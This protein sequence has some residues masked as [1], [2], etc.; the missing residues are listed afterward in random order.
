MNASNSLN[1]SLHFKA[2]KG[3]FTLPLCCAALLATPNFADDLESEE[4]YRLEPTIIITAIVM[5]SKLDELNRN[6][7]QINGEMI[8]QKGFIN[9][10]SVFRY[11]SFVS[12]S[13][14]GLGGNLDIRGQ[15]NKANTSVQTLINGV[16]AN[17]LDSSHG[18]TPIN[19]V[20]PDFI[21]AIEILPGGGAVMFGNGTR[22]G[23]VNIITTKRFDKPYFSTSAGYSHIAPS[24]TNNYANVLYGDKF[25]DTHINVGASYIYKDGPREGERTTGV[26]ANFGV[27]YDFDLGQSLILTRIFSTP[28]CI[29]ALLI[30]LWILHQQA[31]SRAKM[32]ESAQA[33]ANF[34]TSKIASP[35]IW[36]MKAN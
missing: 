15:G 16:Y 5:S 32:T 27:L 2:L 22:G 26:G 6:V 21:Q 29:Q 10:E 25:G 14:T 28:I 30:L 18:V 24:S 4:V 17:M 8:R 20:S 1:Q 33:T 34:T 36:A 7:Y 19:L 3:K 9:T 11:L 23:V 31:A 12:I 35:Q 13:N